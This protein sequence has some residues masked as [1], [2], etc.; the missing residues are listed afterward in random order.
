LSRHVTRVLVALCALT[1]LSASHAGAQTILGM[2]DNGL[3]GL[4]S[5]GTQT[6]N[7]GLFDIVITPGATLAGN[8]AALAAF[9]RAALQWEARIADPITVSINADLAALGA[10]IIGSTS[11]TLLGASYNTIRNQMVVDAADEGAKDAIVASL[12]TAAQ[13][14]GTIPGGG[15]SLSGNIVLTQANAKA[16]GFGVPGGSDGNITFSTAFSFDFDN[17]NGVGAGLVDFETVAAHEIGHLL[18]FISAVDNVDGAA[19]FA[20][21][22]EPLD[23]F[24]FQNNTAAD[25][26]SAAEFTTFARSLVPGG[27]AITDEIAA[28]YRMSTGVTQGDGRQA[29]HWKDDSLTGIN[30]GNM[31]PTLG[32]Q[33]VTP[34]G[35]ADFRALDLIGYDVVTLSSATPEPASIALLGIGLLYARRLRRRRSA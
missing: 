35:N 21:D 20:I 32:N 30:I 16:L 1:A 6:N 7:V 28:E 11:A 2:P 22:L 24:R 4:V 9:N 15:F 5:A 29:S 26:S 34:V 33:V 10:G 25:P 18:G 17:S 27:D 23:L 12:P 13:F 19:A 14:L 3:G 31:D 8:A